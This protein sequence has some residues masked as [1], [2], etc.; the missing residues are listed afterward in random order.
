M[1]YT[2]DELYKT[3]QNEDVSFTEVNN[4]VC[5]KKLKAAPNRLLNITALKAEVELELQSCV[6]SGEINR[7]LCDGYIKGLEMEMVIKCMSCD[8]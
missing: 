2:I 1:E 4:K 8:T 3:F 6:K 7:I 5:R